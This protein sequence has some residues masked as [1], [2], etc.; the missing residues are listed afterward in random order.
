MMHLRVA[1][2]ALAALLA[3]SCATQAPMP[4][5][6]GAPPRKPSGEIRKDPSADQA[7]AQLEASTHGQSKQK[8]VEIYL[9]FRKAYPATTAGED[10]LYKAGVLSFELGDYVNARKQFNEL[11]FENPLFPQAQDARLKL[12]LSALE[13]KS[14]RDAYQTLLPLRE[15]VPSEQKAQLEDA[16]RRAAE[17]ARLYDQAMKM[18]LQKAEQA[19]TPEERTAALAHIG[20]LVDAQVASDEVARVQAELSP[21][22]PAWP[23]LTF[24]LARVYQHTRDV[25]KLKSTLQSLLSNAPSSPYTAEAQEMLARA[26]RVGQVRGRTL[27]VLLPL[28]GKY[29]AFGEAV[30]RGIR[31]AL[32]GSDV[33]LVVKD[34][35]GDGTRAATAV[36]ELVFNDGAV[37]AI[38]PLFI[39]DSK[40]AALVAQDLG[41]PLLTLTRSEDV[42]AIGPFVFRNMPYGVEMTNDFW[43]Q[44]LAQGGAVRGAESYTGDQT[45][46]T[47]QAKK[48]VGR[49]Y[50]EDRRDYFEEV[51]EVTKDVKDSYRRRKAV[52][53]AK[54]KLDPIVDFEALFI[55]D[56]WQRVGLVAPALAVEDIITNTCDPKEIEKLKKTT[57]KKEIRT[58]TLLGGN[59]WNSPK[60]GD[61]VP[62]LVE[63]GGK[64]VLCSVFVDGFYADSDQAATKKFVR[65]YG[66]AYKE[67]SPTLLDA[68]GYDSA[69][70]LRQL[71]D[72][73]TASLD[74]NAVRD[75]LAQM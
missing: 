42:T 67:S 64:F 59:G 1:A 5:L 9:N 22:H 75:A 39:E 69:R 17:G 2:T 51:Q 70:M 40:R 53:K 19:S 71:L 6:P 24:K 68:V 37:A 50:L 14:Y 16:L 44:V 18:A 10:A 8:Q 7:L 65:S 52:A 49:Y 31:L 25:P 20:D 47:T 41:L 12:G 27:G 61:G 28:T 45:T 48:L 23:L 38:G 46:F 26:D 73:Q 57:G 13:L 63:R 35:Q 56:E 74:R 21:T 54:S 58:V 29:K 32:K 33:E 3:A 30:M 34:T 11:L 62:Q 66:E 60:N 43:D 55:P 4:A 36:E 15:R 72:K